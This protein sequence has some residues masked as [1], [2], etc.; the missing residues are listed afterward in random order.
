MQEL[1]ERK[2]NNQY[3]SI[4]KLPHWGFVILLVYEILKQVD[5]INQL[6]DICLLKFE[7][8]F[9]TVFVLLVVIHFIYMKK[10]QTSS[11]PNDTPKSQKL[12]AKIVHYGMYICLAA[13]PIS[14]L[15]IALLFWLDYKS[16][17]LIEIIVG[18]HELSVTLI[19]WLI[20]A[21]ILGI[22]ASAVRNLMEGN[23]VQF[24]APNASVVSKQGLI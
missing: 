9:A 2:S 3:S 10:T 24:K 23:G 20:A 12:A 19:Y 6:E 5:N 8:I 17:F 11:L 15:M 13:I 22:K 7:I 21:H 14:S 1:N 18:I 16:G 4:E